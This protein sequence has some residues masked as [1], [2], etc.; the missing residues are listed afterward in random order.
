MQRSQRPEHGPL[1]RGARSAS[2]APLWSPAVGTDGTH[3]SQA[4]VGGR[5]L[6]LDPD[7]VRALAAHGVVFEHYEMPDMTLEGDVH[8]SALAGAL[9]AAPGLPRGLLVDRL[10]DAPGADRAWL[11]TA[12]DLACCAVVLQHRL[13][14]ADRVGLARA[15]GL[16]CL[17]YTVNDEQDARRLLTLGLD[18]LITDRVDFFDPQSG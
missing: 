18:G 9:A 14:N 16:R 12:A 13:W 15:A 7:L 10:P 2:L 3:Q 1:P 4:R 5:G 11:D 8:V 17:T 6:E